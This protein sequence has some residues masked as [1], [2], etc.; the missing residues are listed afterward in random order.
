LSFIVVE[1]G[2]KSFC[3]NV[4]WAG[5]CLTSKGSGHDLAPHAALLPVRS[6]E[7][8]KLHLFP[9]NSVDAASLLEDEFSEKVQPYRRKYKIRRNN[10]ASK[11]TTIFMVR[12]VRFL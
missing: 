11:V 3:V 2:Q 10:A 4:H 9:K 12:S 7:Q 8:F 5:N 6:E 1:G